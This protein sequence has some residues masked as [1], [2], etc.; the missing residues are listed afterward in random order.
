MA[1]YDAV[2]K[3]FRDG[4]WQNISSQKMVPGDVF[5]VEDKQQVPC[6]AVLLTGDVIAD[7]SGINK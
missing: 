3:V 2:V 1:E 7:E 6:D 5:Q 4:D